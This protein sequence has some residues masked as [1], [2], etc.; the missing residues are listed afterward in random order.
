MKTN[1]FITRSVFILF[2]F[3]FSI[4]QT[5]IAVA[6]IITTFSGVGSGPSD[7]DGGPSTLAHTPLPVYGSFDVFGNY[8][9]GENVN[10]PKIRKINA[11]GIIT[12][13]IGNGIS[14]F[15]GD[16]GPATN[17]KI[18]YPSSP[19]SDRFG[20]IYMSDY[21]NHR[22]RKVSYS[23]GIIN[24][25]AGNGTPTHTGDGGAATAATLIAGDMCID[26]IG[27]LYIL[28]S[29]LIRKIDINGII[30]TIAGNGIGGFSGDGGLA[31]NAKI[32]VGVGICL[33]GNGNLYFGNDGGTRIRKVDLNTGII[34][35]IAGTGNYLYNGDG[36]P[37]TLANFKEIG[38]GFDKFGN[39]YISDYGNQRIRMINK[40]GIIT[41][42]AGTG[43]AGYNGDN[44]LA[45]TAQINGPYGIAIDS[46]G[47]IYVADEQNNRIRKITYPHCNYLSV[48]NEIKS[49]LNLSIY[50]NPT[51]DLVS[52]NGVKNKST[53]I[54]LNIVGLPQ[55]Q[56]IFKEEG[57]N[58]ISMAA[59]PPGIYLLEVIDEKGRRTIKKIVKR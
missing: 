2:L 20:N 38:M 52:L 56:G 24:T 53:Y 59:M 29:A 50:P 45:T 58:F 21:Y 47:N 48:E 23:T 39:L 11:A 41:S 15:S 57:N 18:K 12:T 44:I 28:D 30:T 5:N 31:T 54:L 14:G 13:V 27:N 33:D 37:A 43:V 7:G 34:S 40:F 51:S 55:Q 46:C 19:V 36:I 49:E 22:I 42:V 9:F 3:L 8:Y 6:Q 25:I 35:T 32:L 17:A 1:T 16:G 10:Q 26:S 4:W